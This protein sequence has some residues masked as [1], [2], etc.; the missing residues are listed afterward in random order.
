MR[1]G[2]N[3]GYWGSGDS[4][5]QQVALAQHAERVGYD[6]V[7]VAESYGS[8]AATILGGLAARTSTIGLGSAVFQLPARSAAMTAMTTATLDAMSGGRFRLGLGVSGPQVSEGW[9]GVRFAAPLARTREYVDVVRLALAREP[10]RYDGRHLQLPL[11]DGPG[12]TL[13]LMIRPERTDVPIYLAAVGPKNL[14]LT[15][16]VAQ[17][18]LGLFFAPELGAETLD[19]LRIGRESA[20]HND[21][22]M[23]GFDVSTTVPLA[24]DD[25]PL[26]AADL[27]RGYYALYIGGMGSR[28]KNFYHATA[29]RLGFGQAA[30]EIQDHFLAGRHREA[31]AAVP[32]ELIDATALLGDR[33]RIASRLHR[34][35]EAGVTSLT[36]SPFASNEEGKAAAL[37]AA[38]AASSEAGLAE[39]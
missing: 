8:D 25:D 32:F 13:K 23:D 24:V 14:E 2:L 38:I 6:M 15:G 19:H 3:L 5:E 36:M 30:D 1:L 37:S 12:K 34:Y 27:V 33:V 31:A 22:P 29:T 4:F 35:A 21:S 39:S 9:H 7:W 17:G 11:P 26:A 28:E 16:R 10:V 20:G 18:W